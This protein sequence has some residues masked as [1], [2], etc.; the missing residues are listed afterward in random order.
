MTT[1]GSMKVV[2]SLNVGEGGP[3]RRVLALDIRGPV[4]LRKCTIDEIVLEDQHL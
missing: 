1:V 4:W 2:E 3:T